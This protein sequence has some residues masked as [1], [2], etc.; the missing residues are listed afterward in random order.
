M[1]QHHKDNILNA[2]VVISPTP[3]KWF[4]FLTGA[5]SIREFT[6]FME[7]TAQPVVFTHHDDIRRHF[8][9]AIRQSHLGRNDLPE[10]YSR[11]P[12]RQT[13]QFPELPD[14][15][16]LRLFPFAS[17]LFRAIHLTKH[18]LASSMCQ[19]GPSED[20]A[21]T[22]SEPHEDSSERSGTNEFSLCRTEHMH[23][24]HVG[25]DV[26]SVS[27]LNVVSELIVPREGNEWG[28]PEPP[29]S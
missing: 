17:G 8:S 14:T 6:P 11:E 25:G 23:R 1:Y 7:D 20:G 12:T 3:F 22:L 4:C 24:L 2:N 21:H 29:L 18:L 5:S 27:A 19:K 26:L 28:L 10:A 9:H 15:S 13:L 16:S